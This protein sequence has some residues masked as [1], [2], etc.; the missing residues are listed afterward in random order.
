MRRFT[1]AAL[2][3]LAPLAAPAAD[4]PGQDAY[5]DPLP[6]AAVSRLGT[7]R[8]ALVS[9]GYSYTDRAFAL[10]DGKAAV[11]M[12]GREVRVVSAETGLTTEKWNVKPPKNSYET[13]LLG[14]TAD[15]QVLLGFEHGVQVC[16]SHGK[17]EAEQ[18]LP[19]RAVP[20]KPDFSPNAKRLPNLL[21]SVTAGGLAA[22]WHAGNPYDEKAG[23]PLAVTVWTPKDGKKVGSVQTPFDVINACLL[24]ADGKRLVVAG[25]RKQPK[26]KPTAPKSPAKPGEKEEFDRLAGWVLVFDAG[27]GKEVSRGKV[28]QAAYSAVRSVAISADGAKVYAANTEDGVVQEL[29]A[30]TGQPL[31][32][33]LAVGA[34]QQVDLAA[35]GKTLVGLPMQTSWGVSGGRVFAWDVA[36]G[37]LVGRYPDAPAAASAGG[38]IHPVVF[39]SRLHVLRLPSLQPVSK[40]DTADPPVY[41]PQFTPEGNAVLAR[42][43][44]SDATELFDAATGKAARTP[45]QETSR[46]HMTVVSA[47]GKVGFGL[48]LGTYGISDRTTGRVSFVL[49]G[50]SSEPNREPVLSADG[51]RLLVSYPGLSSYEAKDPKAAALVPA[52]AHGGMVR[53]WDTAKARVVFEKGFARGKGESG[54]LTASL[55]GDG[56]LAVVIRTLAND[57]D[58][59]QAVE[60]SVWEV[61]T[62]KAKST[63]KDESAKKNRF[64]STERLTPL[65]GGTLFVIDQGGQFR[66]WDAAADKDTDKFAGLSEVVADGRGLSVAPDGKLVAFIVPDGGR[67]DGFTGK[68]VLYDAAGKKVGQSEGVKHMTRIGSFSPDGKRLLT[69]ARDHTHLVWDVAKLQA[70]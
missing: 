33:F 54:Q 20:D 1:T 29:D 50:K 63:R 67:G 18:V 17:V 55:S 38:P 62:G 68:V 31:R 23:D 56:Q 9:D 70:K 32:R 21:S 40:F 35:D 52:D 24:S 37:D 15:G 14:V 44:S 5:G 22:S 6:P 42:G 64:R 59:P 47:N 13:K 28:V 2:A 61:A 27:T 16:D 60:W 25:E 11:V 26:D 66:L 53:V 48:G 19:G 12:V 57:K 69:S 4:P 10:P 65:P 45:F 41:D 49:P 43:T 36:S 58:E 30:A 7:S 34:I 3:A 39:D 51:T 8:F 46:R